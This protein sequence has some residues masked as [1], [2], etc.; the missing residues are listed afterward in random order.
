MRFALFCAGAAALSSSPANAL[1]QVVTDS[2]SRP[3]VIAPSG[4]YDVG[5]LLLDWVDST[6]AEL[7]T[8]NPTDRRAL[9]TEIWYP[10]EPGTGQAAAYLTRL[11][12]YGAVW[13]DETIDHLQTVEV[14]WRDDAVVA[15]GRFPV[16]LFSHGWS[17]RVAS[18]STLLANVASHGY[19][20][21]G[22]DHPYLGRVAMAD[23]TVTDPT[24]D[25]FGGQRETEDFYAADVMFVLD[26]LTD[27]DQV[28]MLEGALALDRIAA[29]GHSSGFGSV[30]SG[31]AALDPR[32]SALISF[33]SGVG[34]AVRELGLTQ[35]LLLVRADSASYTDLFFRGPKVNPKGTIYDV[36]FFRRYEGTFYDLVVPGTTHGS[37]FDGYLWAE[38]QEELARLSRVLDVFGTYVVAFLDATLK[39]V[40]TPLLDPTEPGDG[41]GVIL[42]V[43]PH[44]S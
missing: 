14:P 4:P 35:P 17:S 13:D 16:L 12:A 33:D 10:A 43:L 24:E 26:R 40:P 41:R 2:D 42:R 28:G 22:I 25:H 29:S 44:G 23:G 7:A 18:Y 31:A 8:E 20:V 37:V 30:M 32:I 5:H 1:A 3:Q 9:I 6:R 39:A 19:V 34:R 11:D 21:V 27:L 38:D 15:E 36:N